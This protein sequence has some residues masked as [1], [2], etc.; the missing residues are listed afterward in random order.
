M[1]IRNDPAIVTLYRRLLNADLKDPVKLFRNDGKWE[2]TTLRNIG[3]RTLFDSSLG[4]NCGAYVTPPARY[5]ASTTVLEELLLIGDE[6]LK[7]E[8]SA[9]AKSSVRAARKEIEEILAFRRS[10]APDRIAK[11]IAALNSSDFFVRRNATKELEEFGT[12]AGP[13]MRKALRSP[14]PLETRRRLEYLTDRL[15]EPKQKEGIAEVI[16]A[17]DCENWQIRGFAADHLRRL[18]ELAGPALWNG[19][20]QAK[21][22]RLRARIECLL[23]ELDR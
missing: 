19:L 16:A 8:I 22:D 6:A 11:S 5:Q 20:H 18:G 1:E 7:T 21:T 14:L 13:A 12:S 4:W 15:A 3:V 17:L 9:E 23:D 10:G 2:T